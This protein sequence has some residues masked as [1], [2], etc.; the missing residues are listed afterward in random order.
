MGPEHAV[1]T[2]QLDE[3]IISTP[4]RSLSRLFLRQPLWVALEGFGAF[5]GLSGVGDELLNHGQIANFKMTALHMDETARGKLSQH[6]RQRFA[7]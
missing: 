3:G 5:F 2:S 4:R 7:A 6:A 1:R